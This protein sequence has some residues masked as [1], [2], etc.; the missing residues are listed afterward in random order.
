MCIKNSIKKASAS[1]PEALAKLI[2][3]Y[4]YSTTY[5]VNE[6]LEIHNK[7]GLFTGGNVEKKGKKYIFYMF[8]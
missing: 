4:F 6:Q 5:T 3:Q 7:N 2:N 8:A 1:T